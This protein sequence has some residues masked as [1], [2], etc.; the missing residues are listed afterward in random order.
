MHLYLA[1]NFHRLE[2]LLK[3]HSNVSRFYHN[4]Q[5]YLFGLN[6]WIVYVAGE[7]NRQ[8]LQTILQKSPVGLDSH[9]FE[10]YEPEEGIFH[11]KLLKFII[12][13]KL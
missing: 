5:T 9:V 4:E 11:K 13:K 10:F 7:S 2:K 6:V 8:M 1:E 12:Q 3:A